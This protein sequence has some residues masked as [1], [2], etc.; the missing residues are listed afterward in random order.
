MCAGH[1]APGRARPSPAAAL[2]RWAQA[3]CRRLRAA[4]ARRRLPSGVLS[5][6][7]GSADVG[8]FEKLGEDRRLLTFAGRPL[9]NRKEIDV[10][11]ARPQVV[12]FAAF[13]HAMG[14]V[15]GDMRM[16]FVVTWD[17]A[18]RNLDRIEFLLGRA[19]HRQVG[20]GREVA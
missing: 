16:G 4:E 11:I 5:L 12:E 6:R 9:L 7:S 20:A 3:P 10:E 1:A 8:A 19:D 2:R 17:N 14:S 15:A 18:G 13:D